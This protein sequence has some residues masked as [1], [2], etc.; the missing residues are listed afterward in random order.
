MNKKITMTLPVCEE[1]VRIVR[2]TSS[3]IANSIGFN[4]D[5]IEDIKMSISEALIL[6]M[7]EEI[8]EYSVVFIMDDESIVI[9][10]GNYN[11]EPS[12]EKMSMQ[13]IHSLMDEVDF[14]DGLLRLKKDFSNE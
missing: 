10:V 2:M 5:D 12:N 8:N 7:G 13:I 11:N 6:I 14:V 4:I 1:G 3:A 9:E